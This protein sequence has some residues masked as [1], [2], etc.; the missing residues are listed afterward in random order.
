MDAPSRHRYLKWNDFSPCGGSCLQDVWGHSDTPPPPPAFGICLLINMQAAGW[1][2]PFFLVQAPH[3]PDWVVE[4]V[5]V[6]GADAANRRPHRRVLW[7]LP[8]VERGEEHRHLVHVLHHD[9]ERRSV[10]ELVQGQE[11]SVGVIISCLGHH[12]ET[13]FSFEI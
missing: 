12:H 11:A 4:G 2:V 5:A 8:L 10:P 3:L 7:N 9:L 13:S 1:Q 6:V